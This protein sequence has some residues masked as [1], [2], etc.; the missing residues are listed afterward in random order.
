M[1]VPVDPAAIGEGAGGAEIIGTFASR[2]GIK[3]PAGN[4]ALVATTGFASATLTFAHAGKIRH[5]GNAAD[6]A[7]INSRLSNPAAQIKCRV[8]ADARRATIAAAHANNRIPADL[9]P[10]STSNGTSTSLPMSI[11]FLLRLFD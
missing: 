2:A 4:G 9:I 7:G 5:A 11:P 10:A 3:G 6:N 8:A 1:G